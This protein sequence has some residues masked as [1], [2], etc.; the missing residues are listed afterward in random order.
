MD[1]Q[2][3]FSFSMSYD[4]NGQFPVDETAGYSD[5]YLRVH[6][7]NMHPQVRIHHLDGTVLFLIGN[8]IAANRRND[9]SVLTLYKNQPGIKEF[10]RCLNG[11]FLVIEYCKKSKIVKV[12]NDRFASLA[13]FY[14]MQENILHG[15]LSLKQLT[16]ELRKRSQLRIDAMAVFEFLYFRRLFGEKCIEKSCRY[17]SSA[18][19]LDS[20][21]VAQQRTEYK[22]WEPDYEKE[23]PKGKRLIREL[24]A[25]L[26]HSTEQNMSDDRSY[27]LLLSGGLDSR[28]ILASAKYPINCYTTCL[29]KNNEYDVAASVAKAVGANHYFIPRPPSLYD[30]YIDDSVFLTGGQ[31]IY[32]EAQFMGYGEL[33][34]ETTNTLFIGL[35]FDI[36]F[37]GLYLFKKTRQLWGARHY[38]IILKNWVIT[39]SILLSTV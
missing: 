39:L 28:A 36:F 34:K 5:Q 1:N 32:V 22:Y 9:E 37:G 11:S 7:F 3:R 21:L 18:S 6:W 29:E 8:P 23:G 31:Q 19:I 10:A 26:R 35:G 24:A 25:R 20:A 17:L 38:I 12:I 14:S 16:S 4:P 30:P 13:F 15:S 27:G 33:I 2:A